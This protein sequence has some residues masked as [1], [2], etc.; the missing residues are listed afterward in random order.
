M[1]TRLAEIKL[2]KCE[3]KRQYDSLQDAMRAA[4]SAEQRGVAGFGTTNAYQCKFC[5]KFHWGHK[6]R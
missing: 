6:L 4:R 2:R 5:H 1:D 3:R